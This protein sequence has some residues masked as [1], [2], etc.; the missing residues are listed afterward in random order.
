MHKIGELSLKDSTAVVGKIKEVL[1]EVRGEGYLLAE[2]SKVEW[3]SGKVTATITPNNIFRISRISRGNIPG[4]Y[5]TKAGFSDNGLE[6]MNLIPNEIERLIQKLL[7]LYS[8]RGYPFTVIRLDS[9]QLGVSSLQASLHAETGSFIVYDSLRIA[10]DSK[11]S[12]RYLESF[13]DLKQGEVFRQSSIDKVADRLRTI[14]FIKSVKPPVL[15]FTGNKAKITLFLEKQPI[16]QFDGVLGFLPND[17]TGK[18]QFI[19]DLK[20]HLQNAFGRAEQIEFNYKGLPQK[21]KEL[22]LGLNLSELFSTPFGISLGFNLYKQGDDFQNIN[23][24]A[25]FNYRLP[26]GNL[27]LLVQN[28]SASPIN[29][30]T[31][32]NSFPNF[33]STN[34]TTYGVGFLHQNL[35]SPIS[36]TRGMSFTLTAE[37]GK[38]KFSELPSNFDKIQGA[39]QQYRVNSKIDVYL[40]VSNRSVLRFNNETGILV[41]K[42]LFDNELYR[43]GGFNSLKGFNEQSMLASSYTYFNAEYRLMIEN[44]SYLFAFINQ[45]FL[46]R[47]TISSVIKDDPLGFG[48]GINL[49]VNTGIFS[50]SYALGKQKD[51]PLNLQSG[52]IHFGLVTL[53]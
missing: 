44:Y 8:D 39:S 47:S 20:L 50:L 6:G 38:R 28:R 30:D 51:N 53:F 49:R 22:N 10:G 19:G 42:N 33:A 9:V 12:R 17:N 4:D 48:A 37:S 45:G 35:N 32:S 52:K 41:G 5:L 16:N 46:K 27:S 24:R 11:V 31:A 7:T 26:G 14:P 29:L 3:N 2:V 1:A 23:S 15:S 21:S 13:L 36:P 25:S 43:I 18:L 40:P 34:S